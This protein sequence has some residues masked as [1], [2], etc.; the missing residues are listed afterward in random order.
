MKQDTWNLQLQLWYTKND[1]NFK[2]YAQ[3]EEGRGRV[4]TGGG[5]GHTHRDI[6]NKVA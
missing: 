6:I 1:L 5:G 2:L 4:G 3:E